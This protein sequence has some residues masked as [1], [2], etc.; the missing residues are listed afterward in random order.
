MQIWDFEC[1]S[2]WDDDAD[3]DHKYG[4]EYIKRQWDVDFG[5]GEEEHGWVHTWSTSFTWLCPPFQ[6]LFNCQS[7]EIPFYIRF[8]S[9]L[10]VINASIVRRSLS[11]CK[12]HAAQSW[13]NRSPKGF[14]SFFLVK[15][16]SRAHSNGLNSKL[17]SP[18]SHTT[19]I[20]RSRHSRTDHNHPQMYFLCHLILRSVCAL[21]FMHSAERFFSAF[22]LIPNRL[23]FHA[24]IYGFSSLNFS[25]FLSFLLFC[26]F[27]FYFFLFYVVSLFCALLYDASI[28]S[29]RV[30]VCCLSERETVG[31]CGMD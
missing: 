26:C 6:L 18:S 7:Q 22:L 28:K 5:G 31:E 16:L 10:G 30:F 8:G 19:K 14:F 1:F 12:L 4:H 11:I 2:P 13:I 29:Y 27:P 25:V 20:H 23:S 3:W 15:L 24:S 9:R 21:C 17:A